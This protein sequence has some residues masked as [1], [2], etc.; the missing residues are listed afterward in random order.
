VA[1][2]PIGLLLLG[3]TNAFPGPTTGGA[4]RRQRKRSKAAL[5]C[6]LHAAGKQWKMSERVVGT[7]GENEWIIEWVGERLSGRVIV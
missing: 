2:P 6:T 4:T 1:R 5:A 7:E 3:G